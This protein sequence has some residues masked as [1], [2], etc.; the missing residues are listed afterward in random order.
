MRRFA[1]FLFIFAP[2]FLVGCSLAPGNSNTAGQPVDQS[3]SNGSLWESSNGG[4]TWLDKSFGSGKNVDTAGFDIISLAVN[5]YDANMAYAGLRGSGILKTTDGGQSWAYLPFQSQKVYGLELDP[6]DPK[7][8]YASGV[9]QNRGKI[10]KSEDGG[11]NWKEI[12][13]SPANGPLVI[14]LAI[15][16]KN[17]NVIYASTSDNQ[18]IKAID[19]GGSWQSIFAAP[20]PVTKIALDKAND[21]LIYLNVPGQGIFQSTD[22]GVKFSDISGNIAK[23]AK[24]NQDVSVLETDPVNANWVYAAGGVG[25]LKSRDAG[26]NWEKIETLNDPKNFPVKAVAIN[27]SSANEIV[28]GAAQT[29]YKSIDGGKNWITA[30]FEISK[31][32][33]IIKYSTVSPSNLYLGLSK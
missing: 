32:I 9:W 30:Q 31:S 18:V 11:Q 17:S 24:D 13:T 29:V 28:Y 7:I 10:F 33:N 15:N 4:Q 2:L 21:N 26:R 27:P 16:Q 23:V 12:Y 14:A 8:I 22:G 25:I 20:G 1:Y 19:A 5:P 3:K 6:V